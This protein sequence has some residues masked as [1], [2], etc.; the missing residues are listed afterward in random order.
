MAGGRGGF[1]IVIKEDI[2]GLTHPL[3]SEFLHTKYTITIQVGGG[4]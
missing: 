3:L 2:V 1:G 4:G